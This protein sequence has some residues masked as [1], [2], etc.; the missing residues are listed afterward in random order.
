MRHG[1]RQHVDR[2]E[3]A[4]EEGQRRDDQHRDELQLL[5]ALGPDADDEAEQAEGRRGQHQEGD[6]PQRVQDRDR[7]EQRGGRR[8]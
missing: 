6:H 8:G 7:H 2:V 5:E 3:G 1:R 4:A